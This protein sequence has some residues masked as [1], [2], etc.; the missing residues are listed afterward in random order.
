MTR[1]SFVLVGAAV[2]AGPLFSPALAGAAVPPAPT[3]LELAAT[4]AI[5]LMVRGAGWMRVSQPALLAAGLDPAVDPGQL[6]LFAD[7]IEQ[8][9]RITGNGDASFD[10][11]EAIEFYGVGRDTLWTDARTYWLVAGG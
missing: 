4:P 11:D 8:G 2:A 6:R 3:Q 9:I 10:P 1:G 7:G 5:K